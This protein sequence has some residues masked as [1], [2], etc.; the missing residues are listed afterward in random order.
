[1]IHLDLEYQSFIN[2]CKN[3]DLPQKRE[4]HHIRPKSF[5]GN[6]SNEN[7]ILLSFADHL[8]AHFLLW[9][10]EI[11]N[12]KPGPMTKAFFR[13]MGKRK[14]EEYCKEYHG[15]IYEQVR[16]DFSVAQSLKLKGKKQSAEHIEKRIVRGKDHPCYGKKYTEEERKIL[17]DRNKKPK[18]T[19]TRENMRLAQQKRVLLH[20]NQNQGIK[21]NRADKSIKIFVHPDEGVFIGSKFALIEKYPEVNLS[22][23]TG[24]CK[25]GKGS[26]KGWSL[27]NF[28]GRFNQKDN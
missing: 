11:K 1:M 9:K 27:N 16:K 28:T 8:H 4:K 26:I 5:G 17:S 12:T 15:Q 7:L 6:D 10:A 14:D 2:E 18:T 25:T 20:P 19:K 22:K 23:L 24:M 3:K 21:N 13:M